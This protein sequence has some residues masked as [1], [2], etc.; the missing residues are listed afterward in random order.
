MKIVNEKVLIRAKVFDIT[1]TVLKDEHGHRFYRW[2][3]VHPG[4]VAIIPVI[5][6]PSHCDSIILIRQYRFPTRQYLWEL[7]AGTLEKGESPSACARR[8]L[9]EE[10]GYKAGRIRKITA[11]Y[12]CPGFCTEKIHLFIAHNL[13]FTSQKLDPDEKIKYK[14]FT[15]PQIKALIRKNRIIDAKTIIGL[16]LWLQQEKI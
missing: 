6:R 12:S 9:T 4:A 5:R 2:T 1:G 13:R 7:P 3:V 15:R 16:T 11:F 10:T 8:E 14:I